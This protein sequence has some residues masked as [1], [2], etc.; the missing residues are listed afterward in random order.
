MNVPGK[1]ST[2]LLAKEE[3]NRCENSEMSSP[4]V[5]YLILD[6]KAYLGLLTINRKMIGMC[7]CDLTVLLL[8]RIGA[9]C[10]QTIA[11]SILFLPVLIILLYFYILNRK[12][13]LL[14]TAIA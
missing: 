11:F 9:T 2:F 5:T 10:I 6:M 4:T 14:R 8:T 7:G 1:K 13:L 12:R 3:R